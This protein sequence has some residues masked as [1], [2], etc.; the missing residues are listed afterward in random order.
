VLAAP[1]SP[2]LDVVQVNDALYLRP[3]Q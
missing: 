1:M 2:V 3:L